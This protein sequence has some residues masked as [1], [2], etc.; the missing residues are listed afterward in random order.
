MESKKLMNFQ[1]T[2]SSVASTSTQII[3]MGDMSKW[4][5]RNVISPLKVAKPEVYEIDDLLPKIGGFGRFQFMIQ[6]IFTFACAPEAC[7]ALI[8]YFAA[9]IP[10]WSCVANSTNCTSSETFSSNDRTRCELPRDQWEYRAEK[11]YSIVTQFDLDCTNEWMAHAS[12]SVFY[13]GT[14]LGA[15]VWGFFAD[16]YGRKTVMLPAFFFLQVFSLMVAFSPN[17]YVVIFFR[18]MSGFCAPACGVNMNTMLSELVVP[19]HRAWSCALMFISWPI[20]LGSVSFLAYVIPNWKYLVFAITL[21][22]IPVFVAMIFVPESV[23]WLLVH[24]KKEKAME[25]LK[26]TAKVNRVPFPDNAILK[27]IPNQ[28]VSSPADLFRTLDYA[29]L[30]LIQ[31]LTWFTIAVG[32]YGIA[33]ASNDLTSGSKYIN[34]LLTCLMEFPGVLI[35]ATSL[36]HLGRKTSITS[37]LL[38]GGVCLLCVAGIP[39]IVEVHILRLSFGMFGRCC[40]SVVYA[41][42]YVWTLELYPTVLR[43]QA[44]GFMNTVA[45]VGGTAMPFI[46]KSLKILSPVLPFA[47]IGA[48]AILNSILLRRLPETK[49]KVLSDDTEDD[50]YRRQLEDRDRQLLL[51]GNRI[52]YV[53]SI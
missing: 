16:N 22:N 43:S 52:S 31:G 24:G 53:S 15:I 7:H 46:F 38:C 8:M 2:S 45:K 5:S 4:N 51:A 50:I 13:L 34:F 25:V 44:M 9:A 40:F 26:K 41:G 42:I 6:M 37:F 20:A 28:R 39:N 12:S 47:L 10:P 1:E 18:F 14:A 21:P 29:I 3:D 48:L 36:E 49:D 19:K 33:L 23:R 35:C 30:T 11:T 32:F 17:I 27:A